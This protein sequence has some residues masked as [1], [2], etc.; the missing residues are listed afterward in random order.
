MAWACVRFQAVFQ[1]VDLLMVGCHETPKHFHA[2]VPYLCQ[3]LD[4]VHGFIMVLDEE[5]RAN[6]DDKPTVDMLVFMG[7][8]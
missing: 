5:A 6:P 1:V 4:D 3:A 8:G 2:A 7:D